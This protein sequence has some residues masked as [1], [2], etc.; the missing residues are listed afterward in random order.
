MPRFIFKP[1][2]CIIPTNSK[3]SFRN[4]ISPTIFFTSDIASEI[5]PELQAKVN[6]LTEEIKNQIRF[7]MEYKRKTTPTW[8][9]DQVVKQIVGK[10]ELIYNLATTLI[11]EATNILKRD[12][13]VI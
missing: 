4:K 13:S 12:L 2:H 9:A 11:D 10:N 7:L 3:S 5:D 1:S 6:N 8:P